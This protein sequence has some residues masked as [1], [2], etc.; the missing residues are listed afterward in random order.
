MDTVIRTYRYRVKDKHAAELA[1]QAQ[2]VN[3]VWNWCNET[4]RHAVKWG[5][6]WLSEYDLHKLSA[7]GYKELNI[8][9]QTI[10]KVCSQYVASRKQKN[11]PYL[12]YR[13]G[14]SLGWVPF[15]NQV[16]KINGD[17]FIFHGKKY[18]VWFHRDIP[19]NGKFLS[20]SFTQDARKRWYINLCL[21]LP[22]QPCT[23][24]DAIGVDIGVKTIATCSDGEKV[25]PLQLYKQYEEKLAIAQRAHKKKRVKNI[26][27]KIAN[28]RRDYLHKRTTALVSRCAAIFVG[29]VP[30]K[31]FSVGNTAKNALDGAAG[32]FKTMLAYKATTRQVWYEEIDEKWTSQTCSV[33]GALPPERPQ[34]VEGLGIREWTCSSCGSVHDRDINA[35]RNILA[36]G[37]ARLEGGTSSTAFRGEA[38]MV[39]FN[40]PSLSRR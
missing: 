34:G 35:A 27:A 17:C 5:R 8:H 3:F 2:V 18:D 30:A 20:G 15:T 31:L 36:R 33:C 11:R 40:S 38:S 12:R 21:E 24:K 16:V 10:Q 9:A 32:M 13:G 4:Q 22:K 23:G 25:N 39:S 14:R 26:H 6:K 29:S 7:G 28:I 1:R 19:T 37:L